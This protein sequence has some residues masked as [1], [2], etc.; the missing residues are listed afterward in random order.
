MSESWQ[1]HRRASPNLTRPT[2]PRWN[3]L[4]KK[5]AD[6]YEKKGARLTL[7]SFAL[8]IRG[9][10]ACKKHPV[11]NTSLDE[12]AGEIIYKEYFHIGLAVD[13]EQGL[14]VPVLRDV[15]KKDI[16][17][18]FQGIERNGRQER[19]TAKF[20]WKNCRAAPS[21]FPTRAALAARHFTPIINLPE[22]AILGL[23]RALCKPVVRDGKI[24]PR[25]MLPLALVLR[26]SRH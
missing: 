8:K 9:R 11:F 19:A 17:H 25:L 5:H 4:R 15:D 2:S 12:A 22:M 21:P 3:D 18:A 7:T 6:A 14:I 16:A 24:E 23:G 20:R 13:T 10:R 26:S 1:R